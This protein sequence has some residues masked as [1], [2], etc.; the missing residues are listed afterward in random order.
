VLNVNRLVAASSGSRGEIKEYV[1]V[2][3]PNG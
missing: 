2:G 1:I 3:R